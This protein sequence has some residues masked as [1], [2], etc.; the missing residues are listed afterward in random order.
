[1][2]SIFA[3][4]CRNENCFKTA[5][6]GFPNDRKKLFCAE[7]K[8]PNTLDLN[9]KKCSYEGCSI[10]PNYYVPNNKLNQFCAKHKTSDMISLSNKPKC[11]NNECNTIANYN[12][13]TEIIGEYCN[14][15]KLENMVRIGNKKNNCLYEGCKISASYGNPD[16]KH[17]LYC[18]KHKL[19]DM[20][21]LYSSICIIPKCKNVPY[22]GYKT[23]KTLWCHLH[24]DHNNPEIINLI[25]YT[26]CDECDNPYI[27]VS[28][29]KKLCLN[30][31]PRNV[32]INLKKLCKYCDLEE[33]SPYVCDECNQNRNKKEFTVVQ[34]LRKNIDTQFI[35]DSSEM[36]QG[37]SKRRPDIFFELPL[38]NVI[39]EVDEDQHRNYNETCECA[40]I[41]EIVNGIGG[42]SVIFIRFNPDNF[43]INNQSQ[44]VP[45]RERLE[46]LVQVLK[47]ELT[48][49]YDTFQI[50]MIQLF[51]D[52][53]DNTLS[54]NK[55]LSE[56][57]I[58]QLDIT[59]LVTI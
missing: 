46:L 8:L 37:C 42:K 35:Y 12:Y 2:I 9:H 23:G 57:Y 30:H 53:Y 22:Y 19:H 6:F 52:F 1:M 39:V 20:V 25:E 11:K 5:A 49:E 14:I 59:K 17:K 13:K 45:I 38:H 18:T 34:Y 33:D 58:N 48:K 16:S 56:K 4:L 31:A 26:K 54:D 24:Y 7:H 28:N 51:Y 10:R 50:Q 40:R 47:E 41:N 29:E 21:P 3:N 15:H 43:K 36:L 27:I 55:L 44:T 32:E